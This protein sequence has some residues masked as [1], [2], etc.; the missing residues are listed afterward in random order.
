M[1]RNRADSSTFKQSEPA[2]PTP[3]NLRANSSKAKGKNTKQS[4]SAV[5]QS[6]DNTIE[7][8]SSS[9]NQKGSVAR[10]STTTANTSNK[11]KASDFVPRSRNQTSKQQLGNSSRSRS[12]GRNTSKSRSRDKENL[13]AKKTAQNADKSRNLSAQAD[14]SA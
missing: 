13:E 9:L 2:K 1:K 5:G 3:R 4:P 10:N 14:K 7:F 11:A 12:N 6:N 8:S